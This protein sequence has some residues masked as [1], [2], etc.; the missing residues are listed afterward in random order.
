MTYTLIT[1]PTFDAE[2]CIVIGCFEKCPLPVKANDALFKRLSKKLTHKGDVLWHQTAKQNSLL[3]HCGSEKETTLL[4]LKPI[5]QNILTALNQQKITQATVYL[6]QIKQVTPN[7]QI[8]QMVLAFDALRYTPP[9]LKSEPNPNPPTLEVIQFYLE[10]ATD[11]AI[12]LSV[13]YSR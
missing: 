9:H 5:I 6:P 2:H 13:A 4:Q 11:K 3:V 1:T 7:Q 10:Y 12:A 8:E